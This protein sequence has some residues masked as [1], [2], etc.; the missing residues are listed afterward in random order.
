MREDV[1][2]V[3]SSLIGWDHAEH[4]RR[5]AGNLPGH[6]TVKRTPVQIQRSKIVIM[7]PHG[8]WICLTS[9]SDTIKYLISWKKIQ[10]F[11][12]YYTVCC[13]TMMYNIML[14]HIDHTKCMVFVHKI[15]YHPFIGTLHLAPL[16]HWGQVICIYTYANSRTFSNSFSWMKSFDFDSNFIQVC[17]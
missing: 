17:S 10:Y 14:W 11:I 3:T 12:M 8:K 6:H 9:S 16:T 2:Y 5:V 7:K 15:Y 1:T 4:D 13:S